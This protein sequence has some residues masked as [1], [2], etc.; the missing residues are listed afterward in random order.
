MDSINSNGFTQ[1]ILK[2]TRIQNLSHSLID[3]VI[4]NSNYP[5]VTS[6]TIISDISDHFLTFVE[7]EKQKTIV[8]AKTVQSRNFSQ[9]N[10]KK[11]KE[12]LQLMSW[13]SVLNTEDVNEAYDSF[14]SN[15]STL[16]SLHFPLTYSQFNKNVHKINIYM[17]KGLLIS[18]QTKQIL[19]KQTLVD[20]CPDKSKHYR[21]YRNL[22]NKT[23]R[24]SRR[25]YYEHSLK[26]AKRDPKK[27]WSILKEAMNCSS[28]KSKIEKIKTKDEIF[29]QP[30]D[31]A[32][33][34]NNFFSNIGNE[35][36]SSVNET[37]T[38]PE[39]Y[40]P[41]LNPPEL[42]FGNQSQ[43][44]IVNIIKLLQSKNSTDINGISVRLLKAVAPEIGIPLAHIFNLSLQQGI[45]PEDLK[46][47]KVVPILKSGSDELC[48]NYR[49]ISLLNSISKILEKI[50][51]IQLSN[52]IELKKLINKNQFGFQ[53]GK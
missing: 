28:N 47:S 48:D 41:E 32:N 29:T 39:S 5:N 7:I 20:P 21:T 25:S 26:V 42:E 24:A 30:S 19:Y 45:F 53:K 18:R 34:F 23:V 44:T 31:I 40:V 46:Q 3:H 52:H 13:Q 43:G 51:A 4:S 9:S 36:A 10:I 35:I 16:F 2:A 8:K 50:V 1:F 17:T 15:F 14:W 27:T 33:S 6:G 12:N 11:F 37:V 38:K 49:P 22:F